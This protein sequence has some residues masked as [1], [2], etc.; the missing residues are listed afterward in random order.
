MALVNVSSTTSDIPSSDNVTGA[1]VGAACAS[2]SASVL[3]SVLC[4]VLSSTLSVEV[5]SVFC[6]V[7]SGS[8]VLCSRSF[9]FVSSEV[10]TSSIFSVVAA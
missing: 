7:F 10:V 6:P 4:S 1:P 8:S 2:G 5:I 9:S 3:C